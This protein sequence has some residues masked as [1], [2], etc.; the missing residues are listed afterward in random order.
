MEWHK[1]NE[2]EIKL[3]TLLRCSAST[4][5][6]SSG[7]MQQWRALSRNYRLQ[8]SIHR[9]NGSVFETSLCCIR[10]NWALLSSW[11]LTTPL[12][13]WCRPATCAFLCRCRMSSFHLR[14]TPHTYRQRRSETCVSQRSLLLSEC[15]AWGCGFKSLSLTV[16]QQAS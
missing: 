16:H 2:N 1:Y 10:I 14:H 8:K 3:W 9:S 5:T 6:P 4:Q 12:S 15:A 11:I 7:C 13:A